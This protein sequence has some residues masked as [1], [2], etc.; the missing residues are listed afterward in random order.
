MKC[1]KILTQARNEASEDKNLSSAAPNQT[2]MVN[3]LLG[4]YKK[5]RP[6][7][8][9]KFFEAHKSPSRWFEMRLKYTRSVAVVSIIGYILG[10]GD[11]H[12]SNLLLD[13]VQGE[14]VPIDFG[15]AFDGVCDVIIH[16]RFALE[17]TATLAR[18][19]V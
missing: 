7:L 13:V 14:L 9:Y 8:R 12:L 6:V 16:Y 5:N 4:I 1:R 2:K 19:P 11:R 3:A 10:I 18:Q 15:Y 17:L